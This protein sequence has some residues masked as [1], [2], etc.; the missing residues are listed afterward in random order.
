MSL[1][2]SSVTKR[3]RGNAEL[4]NS[5]VCKLYVKRYILM[6]AGLLPM[7]SVLPEK[8]KAKNPLCCHKLKIVL[9]FEA[10]S[11]FPNCS[12]RKQECKYIL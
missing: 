10:S 4:L 5:F 1:T 11:G 8:R 9:L 6:Q 12:V 7:L 2:D 3:Q